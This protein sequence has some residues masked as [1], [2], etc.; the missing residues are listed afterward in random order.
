VAIDPNAHGLAR[1]TEPKL[2]LA[3][4]VAVIDAL[5]ELGSDSTA[6]GIRWPNDVLVY[7]R[8]IAG[9]LPESVDT[10]DGRRILIG[11]GINVATD[12]E[13]MPSEIRPQATTLAEFWRRPVDTAMLP[14]VLARTLDH[15]GS[16]LARLV[17]DDPDLAR[18]WNA[19]DV[20][21][22]EWVTVGLEGRVV[23]GRGCEIEEDGSLC[24]EDGREKHRVIG[25]QVLR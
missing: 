14:L 2:A 13:A 6:L 9:I 5:V 11:V 1:E 12:R 8:K 10:T 3:T 17:R 4:A 7:G 20:L 22:G 23:A 25:G 16:A 15:F 24:L 18:R 21:H 19:L